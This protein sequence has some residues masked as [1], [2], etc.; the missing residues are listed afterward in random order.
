M[1]KKTD[2]SKKSSGNNKRKG[3]MNRKKSKEEIE[4]MHRKENMMNVMKVGFVLFI[5]VIL[6][7]LVLLGAGNGPENTTNYDS[8]YEIIGDEFVIPLSD[9]TDSAKYYSYNTGTNDIKFFAVRGSDGDVHTA[10]DAC[11]VCFE[12]KK[13]YYQ[14]GGDMVCRNCGNRYTTNQIG[15]ANQGGGCWP[16]YMKRTIEGDKVKIKLSEL[17]GGSFYFP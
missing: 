1:A 7:A 11:E 3:R 10:F 4:A 5:I 6:I 16:G 8:P 12:A 13:G 17:E 15:T 9:V 14:D 2:S